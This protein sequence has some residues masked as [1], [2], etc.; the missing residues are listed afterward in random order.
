MKIVF[1][2]KFLKDIVAID[3]KRTKRA[4]EKIIE[5]A[6]KVE[7]LNEIS[8]LKK[9][10]G[11]KNAYRIRVGD[12]RIGICIEQ[13]TIEFVRFLHRKDIYKYFP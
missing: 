10:K 2:K 9:L 11:Y 8:T 4:G 12:Y 1:E 6:E 3:N 5:Q 13:D 7:N